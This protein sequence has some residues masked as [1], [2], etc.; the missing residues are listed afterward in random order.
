MGFVRNAPLDIVI[1]QLQPTASHRFR[2]PL[3]LL[4]ALVVVVHE[5]AGDVAVPG[6]HQ[7]PDQLMGAF[8]IVD[9]HPG[10][11]QIPIEIVV[12]DHRDP[13]PVEFLV[14]VEI[15][16]EDARLH[17]VHDKAVEVLVH[18]RFQTAALVAELVVGQEDVKVY[19]LLCQDAAHPFDEARVGAG[20]LSLQNKADLIERIVGVQVPRHHLFP[21]EIGPAA[22][23]LVDEAL[24]HQ[25]VDGH[26]DRFPADAQLPAEGIFRGKALV[27]GEFVLVDISQKPAIYLIGF[28]LNSREHGQALLFSR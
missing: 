22:L 15:R 18:H 2:H 5:D 27:S 13:A 14:A 6:I 10:A 1:V 7:T 24:F 17:A 8:Y 23:E 12:E 16:A 3:K 9:G 25:T 26:P 11:A 28:F 21:V 4:H 20:I 19:L